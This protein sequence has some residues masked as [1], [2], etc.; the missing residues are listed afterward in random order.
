MPA[1]ADCQETFQNNLP[2]PSAQRKSGRPPLCTV[3]ALDKKCPPRKG[4][5]L[6]GHHRGGTAAFTFSPYPVSIRAPPQEGGQSRQRTLTA[7]GVPGQN[8]RGPRWGKRDVYQKIRKGSQ[9]QPAA[10]VRPS[11]RHFS[12]ASPSG[13][14][15]AMRPSLSTRLA[16]AFSQRSCH[17]RIHWP[18]PQP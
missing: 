3:W 16:L 11:S 14:S 9:Y 17:S 4:S 6:R 1:A 5:A 18:S 12:C 8:A 10:S 13:A 15:L 7:S 2:R